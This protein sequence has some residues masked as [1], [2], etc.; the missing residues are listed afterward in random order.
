ML[1]VRRG[2]DYRIGE[3][4]QGSKLSPVIEPSVGCQPE[5]IGQLVAPIAPWIGDRH[6][7]SPV[8]MLLHKAGERVPP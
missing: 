7:A 6:H 4:S 2:D 3:P 5:S 1:A 8:R